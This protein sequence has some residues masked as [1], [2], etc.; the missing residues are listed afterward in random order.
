MSGICSPTSST[1]SLPEMRAKEPHQGPPTAGIHPKLRVP[2]KLLSGM[3]PGPTQGVDPEDEGPSRR[4]YSW[5]ASFRKIALPLR[6]M[7]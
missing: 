3:A 6:L 1:A 5:K 7:F 2:A 4:T